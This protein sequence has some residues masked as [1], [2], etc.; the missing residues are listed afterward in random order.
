MSMKSIDASNFDDVLTQVRRNA[1]AVGLAALA[2]RTPNRSLKQAHK[3]LSDANVELTRGPMNYT[4]RSLKKANPR[5]SH[6]I[7]EVLVFGDAL[8][9]AIGQKQSPES[10]K[11]D[12]LEVK[13]R[14]A[15]IVKETEA[16]ALPK[17]EK[18]L[19]S[20]F[21]KGS[22]KPEEKTELRLEALDQLLE[23]A[24]VHSRELLEKTE[25]DL[26]AE[27]SF[28]RAVDW[29]ILALEDAQ[30]RLE[31]AEQDGLDMPADELVELSN[32]L[33]AARITTEANMAVSDRF[34]RV[35]EDLHNK[36]ISFLTAH[37]NTFTVIQGHLRSWKDIK[38]QTDALNALSDTVKAG[39]ALMS[40]ASIGM[41]TAVMQ[42]WD[43]ELISKETLSALSN[44][45]GDYDKN[46]TQLVSN[47]NATST[48]SHTPQSHW[49]QKESIVSLVSANIENVASASTSSYRPTLRKTADKQ[50]SALVSEFIYNEEPEQPKVASKPLKQFEFAKKDTWSVMDKLTVSKKLAAYAKTVG[51]TLA[52]QDAQDLNWT[53]SSTIARVSAPMI[54]VGDKALAQAPLVLRSQVDYVVRHGNP[55]TADWKGILDQN[56]LVSTQSNW[57]EKFQNWM[58]SKDDLEWAYLMQWNDLVYDLLVMDQDKEEKHAILSGSSEHYQKVRE[59]L[60]ER[61]TEFAQNPGVSEKDLKEWGLNGLIIRYAVALDMDASTV[62][63]LWTLWHNPKQPIDWNEDLVSTWSEKYPED[64]A[65]AAGQ[66]IVSQ[67]LDGSTPQ[68]NGA[69]VGSR[70]RSRRDE[71]LNESLKEA[72]TENTSKSGKARI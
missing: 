12:F 65:T 7:E 14:F 13:Q 38:T 25:K 1:P 10:L 24:H 63:K 9:T 29:F 6:S 60:V 64:M 51:L 40:N 44:S 48:A 43:G 11:A 52:A 39:A 50:S 70:L 47:L 2:G 31:K 5:L 34:L 21:D 37:E 71:S 27:R 26:L 49:D 42:P 53:A 68:L 32:A 58:A 16:L 4:W 41:E 30:Q 67:F 36:S 62:D 46:I 3:I 66:R 19:F 57:D 28:H 55:F 59:S 8:F 22:K 17:E 15:K 56:V 54:K 45:F 23:E 20:F 18:G 69:S 72:L 33:G 35:K 61:I